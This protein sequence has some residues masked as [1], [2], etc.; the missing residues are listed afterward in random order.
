MNNDVMKKV[1]L[2]LG[3]GTLAK[4]CETVI[5][6]ILEEGQPYPVRFT[7]QLPP[8]P[9][10]GRLQQ[11]WQQLYY[12]RNQDQVFRIHLLDTEGF[13]YSE[14]D[15][16]K[17]SQALA[18]QLNR[19]LTSEAFRP[20]D[21]MLR[22]ELERSDDVQ[23]ILEA[24]DPQIRRLPWHLWQ[25][26]ED[27]PNVELT[28]SASDWRTLPETL[29]NT[30]KTKILATFGNSEGLDLAADLAALNQLPDTKLTVL[31]SPEL[32]QLHESLW[33]PSGWDIFF[34]AGHSQT[35]DNTGVIDLNH[36]DRLTIDQIKHALGKAIANGLK[37]AI[38]NSCDG[39]GLAQQLSAL[40]IPY[41]VVM[42]E[43]VPDRI[44]QQ[45]L[46]Y[47]L[48]AFAGGIPFHLAVKE[49]RRRLSGL[50]NDIPCASWLPIIWQNPTAPPIYW[51]DFQ[52]KRARQRAL[53]RKGWLSPALKGALSASAVVVIR[54]LGLLEP[55]E[56]PLYDHLMRR[57]PAEPID[58]RVVVVEITQDAT[59]EYGYPLPDEAL[60]TLVEKLIAAE[61]LAIG[62]DLH[63]P[64]A[65]SVSRQ[66]FS[67]LTITESSSITE[68]LVVTQSASNVNEPESLPL[69][70]YDRFLQQVE[71]TPTLF[72]VCAYG[73][74][75]EN[76]RAPL[77]LSEALRIDQVGFSDLPTDGFS[78]GGT[79]V[80]GDVSAQGSTA[81]AGNKVRRH[82]LTYDPSL[83]QTPSHCI[84]PYS[85]SFHLAYEYL[86]F[87]NVSPLDLT[88]QQ[89]W[90]FGDAVFEPL[91]TR[92]G[93]Y[94]SLLGPTDQVVL[95][96]RANQPAGKVTLDQILTDDFDP[97]I[98]RDRV[99]MVGYT[100]PVSKDY[101]E[102][103]YGPMPG[104]WIHAHMVSQLISAPLDNRPI[105]Y[106]LP[107][108]RSWQWGD[109]LWIVMWSGGAAYIGWRINRQSL[110]TIS[111][112]GAVAVLYV[113]CWGAMI[114]GLWLPM[115]PTALAILVATSWVRLSQE[116]SAPLL[117]QK[118]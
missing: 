62:L 118:S 42:R 44:A 67:S 20:I 5:G 74:S 16:G 31:E 55:F 23:L 76:Y 102:T 10:L 86:L 15:F 37:I 115:L 2:N 19:W 105:I 101:F 11:Q 36:K 47:L 58:S 110:W 109:V 35:Q 22:T 75:D 51:E 54:L 7:A 89:H 114:F 27:Y 88:E 26:C 108:W 107:Q 77:G 113:V 46:H 61:P 39:L 117:N 93:G 56:L 92:F 116:A 8:A 53:E 87:K 30:S 45:F 65:L 71:N 28:F 1:I 34:F 94:Q 64:K 78:P 91:S 73:S 90:Q 38:F 14:S 49:A 59:S 80:R 41:I 99:V 40:Q 24:S 32:N 81:V 84:T 13:R 72:L 63:R 48:T 82:I 4:G 17:T 112:V 6:E 95:N 96:Y 70:A 103:P 83:S 104:I 106:V 57:R 69:S 68:G 18:Q 79:A 97:A 12:Q 111:T 66:S 60:T 29:P 33:Q 52:T 50:D 100:A 25:L 9:E 3:T 98:L 21:Q 85:L 43:P